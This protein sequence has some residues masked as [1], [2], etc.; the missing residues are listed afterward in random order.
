MVP[1]CV[2]LSLLGPELHLIQAESG[3]A[4][5]CG[6]VALSL[7]GLSHLNVSTFLSGALRAV[8]MVSEGPFDSS[9]IKNLPV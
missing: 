1:Q 2:S 6:L 4:E 5:I 3:V 9:V 8:W 7:L